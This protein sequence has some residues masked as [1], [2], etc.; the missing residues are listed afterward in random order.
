MSRALWLFVPA[1]GDVKVRLSDAPVLSG[2]E[3]CHLSLELE[4]LSKGVR[5]L[6]RA[7]GIGVPELG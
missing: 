2:Y 1:A 7:R 6:M 4:R 3:L 5:I